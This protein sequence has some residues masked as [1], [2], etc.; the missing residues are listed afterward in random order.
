MGF[1]KDFDFDAMLALA[2]DA[3]MEF[4]KKRDEL[5]R[6]AIESC[7]D[8]KRG[9]NIQK[10]IDVYRA[11]ALEDCQEAHLVILE[12]GLGALR[13][14]FSERLLAIRSIS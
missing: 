14:R 7:A 2:K 12:R 6:C 8:P 4:A 13:D 10:E 1:G 3:P 5:I 9:E 11:Q